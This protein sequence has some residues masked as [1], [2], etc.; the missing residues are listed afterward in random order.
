MDEDIGGYS[1]VYDVDK[2]TDMIGSLREVLD[3]VT[4]DQLEI[5][6][7]DESTNSNDKLSSVLDII[8]K[9]IETFKRKTSKRQNTSKQP[10]WFD[11]ECRAL[12]REKYKMVRMYR[13]DRTINN[14]DK[15][16]KARSDFKNI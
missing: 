13:K 3:S 16:I 4:F 10:K 8:Y 2:C 15:Y 1:Y 12:K 14:L 9:S 7:N 5:D 6:F 11:E